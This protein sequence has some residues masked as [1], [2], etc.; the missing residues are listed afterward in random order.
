MTAL[1]PNGGS[2]TSSGLGLA[3]PLWLNCS[4]SLARYH[5]L[6]GNIPLTRT[7]T[8]NSICIPH[9]SYLKPHHGGLLLLS[10]GCFFNFGSFHIIA[11]RLLDFEATP[12][13]ALGNQGKPLLILV[14]APPCQRWCHV[15]KTHWVPAGMLV[16]SK[17]WRH[18]W[19]GICRSTSV[20]NPMSFGSCWYTRGPNKCCAAASGEPE[21][22]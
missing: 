6:G 7:I 21:M 14:P 13:D 8:I 22:V 1:L 16:L 10:C 12:M 17:G 9:L 2:T 5:Q 4:A 20:G 15:A 19:L 3:P 11:S 18:H